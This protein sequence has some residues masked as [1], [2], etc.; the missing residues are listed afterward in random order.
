VIQEK[1]GRDHNTG[2]ME[3]LL[4]YILDNNI[5]EIVPKFSFQLGFFYP[6]IMKISTKYRIND[7]ELLEML[8]KHKYAIRELHDKYVRCPYCKSYRLLVQLK[9][10]H[11]GSTNVSKVTLVSHVPCGYIGVLEEMNIS[12]GKRI[13]PKCEKKLGAK[14]KDWLQIGSLYKCD[15]C[16]E[17][18]EIPSV[19][20]KCVSCNKTFGYKEAE[21]ENIYKYKINF[22][23]I[24]SLTKKILLKSIINELK[25][26]NVKVEINPQLTGLSGLK[27][28]ATLQAKKD[29]N[30]L[31]V[32]ILFEGEIDDIMSIYGKMIDLGQPNHIILIP[33]N[34]SED[35]S[36]DESQL[37]IVKY[38]KIS[39]IPNLIRKKI[40]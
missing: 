9:C 26:D 29:N 15:K 16:G 5:D 7:Q 2:I 20:F 38:D 25:K 3:E 34:I 19:Q 1:V 27:H 10:P 18:F 22:E 24:K 31:L 39:D 36:L 37:K 6:E 35:L 17:L 33:K 11:C 13:C 12:E 40:K 30:S 4:L 21:Y 32:D 8:V 28:T 14:D 23:K